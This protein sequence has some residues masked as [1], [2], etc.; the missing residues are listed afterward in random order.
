MVTDEQVRP[1]MSLLNQGISQATAA[2]K[3]GMSERTPRKQDRRSVLSP[4][5]ISL[6]SD[7]LQLGVR[8]Y[9]PEREL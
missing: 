7:L 4:P 2:A 8:I 3:A 1:L 6:C 9:L 5:A